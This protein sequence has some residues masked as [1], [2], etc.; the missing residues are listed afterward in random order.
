MSAFAEEGGVWGTLDTLVTKYG[1]P[2]AENFLYGGTANDKHDA[3]EERIRYTQLNGS[4]PNDVNQARKAPT[5]LWE[6]I[7]GRQTGEAVAPTTTTAAA[8]APTVSL[9]LVLL[10]GL[11]VFFLWRK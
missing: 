3:Q 4:G 11:A 5:N 10:V 1:T 2:L 6:F 7:F 8:A 9:G